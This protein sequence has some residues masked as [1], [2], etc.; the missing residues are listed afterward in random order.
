MSAKNTSD[1]IEEYLK[2]LLE[3]TAEIEIKRSELAETFDVVPSQINYVIKTR[4]TL[5]RGYE[6]ESKRGG[7][8]YIKIVKIK[9]SN[10]HVL[11]QELNEKIPLLLSEK[12]A[13]DIVQFLFEEELISYREGNFVLAM[14]SDSNFDSKDSDAF[15][16]AMLKSFLRRLDRE[17]EI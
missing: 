9:Y 12:V 15:R 7:G 6:V 2:K 5:P 14:L 3:A 11:L 8:G 4:F 1:M 17:D 16:S 13:K 10:K